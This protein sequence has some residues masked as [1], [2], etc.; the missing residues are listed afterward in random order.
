MADKNTEYSKKG[1]DDIATKIGENLTGGDMAAFD[2]LAPLWPSAG[3]FARAVWL[4]QIMDH[5]RNDFIAHAQHLKYTFDEMSAKLKV[6][7]N[8]FDNVDG[9]NAQKIKKLLGETK[10][11]ITGKMSDWD[12]KTEKEQGN[13]AADDGKPVNGYNKNFDAPF[14][15]GFSKKA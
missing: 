2:E 9:D 13:H 8:D 14:V 3:K 1:L 15:D 12:T 5:R 4:E 11:S 6:I 7:S 10:D